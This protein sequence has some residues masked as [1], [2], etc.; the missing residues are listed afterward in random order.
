MQ[1]IRPG[2]GIIF[3]LALRG[4]QK[5]AF[6]SFLAILTI[7]MAVGLFLSTW[8]INDDTRLAFHHSA[9]GFDAVLGARGSKLQIILNSLF[10][11]ESSPGNLSWEQY[12]I[13]QNTKGVKEAYPIAVGDNYLGYRLVGTDPELLTSHQWKPGQGYEVEEG[14]RVFS[15]LAKEAVVGSLVAQKVGLQV[16]DQFHP[17]HGLNFKEENKHKDIY[18]VVGILEATGTPADRVIW[19]PIKGIQLMDGHDKSMSHS[20]SAVL[21][22]LKGAAGFSLDMKYN[23]QGNVATLAWPVASTLSSF[24][25]KFTWFQ[26]ILELVAGMIAVVG[27]LIIVLTLRSS[28]NERRREFAILRCLG[29]SRQSVS[30]V[31]ISQ[32]LILACLGVMAGFFVHFLIHIFV[33]HIIQ[34]NTGVLMSDFSVGFM[35]VYVFCAVLFVGLASGI[36]P[37]RQVYKADLSEN[38]KHHT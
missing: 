4:L 28:M 20:L 12:E 11:L 31:I 25:D 13:I 9:G 8:K 15:S 33:S 27:T 5:H 36:L 6:S 32:S 22:S 26:K 19:V 17:Y 10:H 18:V 1:M 16:G 3:F 30:T 2:L 21:L 14:G 38:L 34:E 7:A 37:A 29:A 35:G 24:F 23:R